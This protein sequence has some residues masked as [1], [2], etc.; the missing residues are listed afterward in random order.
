MHFVLHNADATSDI[1]VSKQVKSPV[2]VKSPCTVSSTLDIR[3]HHQQL[4]TSVQPGALQ[5]IP[6]LYQRITIYKQ[7]M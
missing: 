6:T 4:L 3:D 1:V 2:T 5:P 7:C